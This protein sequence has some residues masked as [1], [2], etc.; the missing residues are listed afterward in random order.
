MWGALEE[1]EN[2]GASPAAGV[3]GRNSIYEALLSGDTGK[4]P[5]PSSTCGES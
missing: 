2:V 5:F 4:S 1:E 3:G